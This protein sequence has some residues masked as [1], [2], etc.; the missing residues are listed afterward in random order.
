MIL[1]NN[2]CYLCRNSNVEKAFE[3]LGWSISKCSDC[4]LYR[5]D[6]KGSYHKFISDYYN[7]DFFT[8]S[9]QRAGYFDYEGD[10]QAEKK[11]MLQYLNGITQFKNQ[12]RLLDVGCATG[13]FMLEAQKKN[14]KVNGI[15]VSKYAIDI[16]KQRFGK[17]VT[18]TS[19][20]KANIRKNTYDVITLFDVIEHVS[21]PRKVLK[22]IKNILN[23]NGLLVI[24][25]GD[26]D[27]LMA[28]L[29]GKNWHFFIPPQ[30]FFYFSQRNLTTLLVELG[31]KVVRVDRKGKWITLRYLFHLARQIE[32]SP[33]SRFGFSLFAKIAP[34]KIPLYL[35]LF[36]NITLYAIKT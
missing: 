9:S 31:F 36:D 34:G 10:R 19:F 20:E 3:K 8:G 35:N 22:K 2:K 4:K 17:N 21:D 24:N 28:K 27:S 33:L 12:G 14:F 32:Q 26:T 13:L 7:K 29:Q 16:A 23:E 1:Q 25:T 30:H 11:N 5:L 18:Q 6:F 15:D